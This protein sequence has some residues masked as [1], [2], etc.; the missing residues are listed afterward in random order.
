[1]TDAISLLDAPVV[2][3]NEQPAPVYWA[4]DAFSSKP[5]HGNEARLV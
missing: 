1:M 3:M 4:V 5:T 2:P